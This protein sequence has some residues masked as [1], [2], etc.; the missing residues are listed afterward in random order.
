MSVLRI[1]IK[2]KKNRN[3]L[4]LYS[5]IIVLVNQVIA[6]V[7]PNSKTSRENALAFSRLLIPKIDETNI[8]TLTLKAVINEL[9]KA[10][11]GKVKFIAANSY[12]PN[13]DAK[14]VS[15]TLNSKTDII[16]INAC[17]IMELKV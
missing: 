7:K 12:L 5:K 1:K 13:L 8:I 10:T 11:T 9:I 2:I 17:I 4:N 6:Q 15:T 3:I 16:P 14:N